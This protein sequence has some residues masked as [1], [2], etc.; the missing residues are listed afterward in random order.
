MQIGQVLNLQGQELFL[1][2]SA[3]QGRQ[4]WQATD[5]QAERPSNDY[6]INNT[7]EFQAWCKNIGQKQNFLHRTFIQLD[8]YQILTDFWRLKKHFHTKGQTL[9]ALVP[10]FNNSLLVKI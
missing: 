7:C 6:T 2:L 9:T 1:C 8:I 5:S 4:L 3:Y 10:H